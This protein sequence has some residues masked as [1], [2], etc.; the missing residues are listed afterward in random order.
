MNL[1]LLFSVSLT[2]EI[3]SPQLDQGQSGHK[4]AA[5]KPVIVLSVLAMAGLLGAVATLSAKLVKRYGNQASGEKCPLLE[6]RSVQLKE[7]FV[8]VFMV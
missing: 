5:T 6:D 4:I 3:Y 8:I 7:S 2:T 1:L